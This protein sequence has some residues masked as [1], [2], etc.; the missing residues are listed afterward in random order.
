[1]QKYNFFHNIEKKSS[2]QMTSGKMGKKRG[3]WGDE[4][5]KKDCIFAK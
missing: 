2:R 1:L 3:N 4:K 5:W